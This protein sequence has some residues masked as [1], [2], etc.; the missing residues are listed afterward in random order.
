MIDFRMKTFLTV[1]ECMN[2]TR[3]VS[4]T[5]LFN[6]CH[7]Y[8][9]YPLVNCYYQNQKRCNKDNYYLYCIVFGSG[10][11]NLPGGM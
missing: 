10:S 5:H 1:C 3:A 11:N 2:F 6:Q 7:I 8:I 9:T 4:Y